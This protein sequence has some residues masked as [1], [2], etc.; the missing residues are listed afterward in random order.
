[1]F[2]SEYENDNDSSDKFKQNIVDIKNKKA[3]TFD[4]KENFSQKTKKKNISKNYW[5]NKVFCVQFTCT[6]DSNNLIFIFG[7]WVT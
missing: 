7:K 3:S 6:E 5:K 2:P 1:V 4:Q